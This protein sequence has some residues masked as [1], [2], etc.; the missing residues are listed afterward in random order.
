MAGMTVFE[1]L[2]AA[3]TKNHRKAYNKD[4]KRT[5]KETDYEFI[6]R[7]MLN[8]SSG[9]LNVF[10][11]MPKPAQDYFDQTS[12]TINAIVKGEDLVFPLP[13]GFPS[14]PKVT[15]KL[16]LATK[17]KKVEPVEEEPVTTE[18]E[19]AAEAD[20]PVTTDTTV[21]DDEAALIAKRAARQA[22][23]KER[24]AE[25]NAAAADGVPRT[26]R[27]RTPRERMDPEAAK[28]AR[29]ARRAERKAAA[30]AAPKENIGRPDASA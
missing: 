24:R 2:L 10:E 28:L 20:E 23:R 5:A 26:P 7:L 25:R 21:D 11:E 3:A 14:T 18:I 4:F 27:T 6:Q 12:A 30:A 29:R 1:S 15:V 16:K 22:R 19:P 9:S 13:E 17:A 8:L